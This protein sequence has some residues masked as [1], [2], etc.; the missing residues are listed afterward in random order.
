[1]T[2]VETSSGGGI[3]AEEV[4]FRSMI[5][6]AGLSA[7]IYGDSTSEWQRNALNFEQGV[8]N[9]EALAAPFLPA[10]H[11]DAVAEMTANYRARY[12]EATFP[13][14]G[15]RVPLLKAGHDLEVKLTLK[16][17]N[18]RLRMVQEA[19]YRAGIFGQRRMRAVRVDEVVAG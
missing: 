14:A 4:L 10:D 13:A 6:L 8:N 2:G 7:R 15:G 16:I 12:V 19:L 17:A 11:M 18:E 9:T 1:M 5:D 3:V